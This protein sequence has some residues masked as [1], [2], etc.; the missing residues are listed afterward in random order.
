MRFAS[1]GSAYLRLACRRACGVGIKATVRISNHRPFKAGGMFSVQQR[2][3]ERL[4]DL[5]AWLNR[6]VREFGR[7][8]GPSEPDAAA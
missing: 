1:T 8:P 4:N 5:V 2:E 3:S 6:Q 7:S